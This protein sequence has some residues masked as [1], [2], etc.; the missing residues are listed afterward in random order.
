MSLLNVWLSETKALIATDT[1]SLGQDGVYHEGSKMLHLPHANV[2]V[3]GRGH[4]IFLNVVFSMLHM[5]RGGFDEYESEM[6][7]M[8]AQA[9]AY[10][11]PQQ[12]A[13]LTTIHAQEIV[14]VGYSRSLGRMHCVAYESKDQTGFKVTQIDQAFLSPWAESWG[15]PMKAST[16][17]DARIVCTEQVVNGKATDPDAPLG[18]RLLLAELTRHELKFSTIARLTERAISKD[19]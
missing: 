19:Q 17:Q 7:S 16:P 4:N 9:I 11:E 10:L 2:V 1:E 5:G 3:G 13:F 14:L 8:L 18:G 6:P 12:A 15:M